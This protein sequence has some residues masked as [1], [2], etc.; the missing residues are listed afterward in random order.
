MINLNVS[1]GESTWVS[2][3]QIR[4]KP[5]FFM[6]LLTVKI[7]ILDLLIIPLLSFHS[8]ICTCS[9][10]AFP[11]SAIIAYR[12]FSDKH[13]PKSF[14]IKYKKQWCTYACEEVWTVTKELGSWCAEITTHCSRIL[15]KYNFKW[16]QNIFR[17]F[18]ELG[19]HWSIHLLKQY[20]SYTFKPLCSS[21]YLCKE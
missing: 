15:K 18:Q 12:Y 3:G 10:A 16:V 2:N 11:L 13:N 14:V 17:P 21:M 9:I 1:K 8:A 5:L 20:L 19:N 7:L 4:F 6:P